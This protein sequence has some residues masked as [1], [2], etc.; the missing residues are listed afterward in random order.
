M[1]TDSMMVHQL[2][3]LLL[4]VWLIVI[5]DK[6]CIAADDDFSEKGCHNPA[7]IVFVLDESGSI[8]GPH[9]TK[10]LEFVQNVVDLFDV[11]P[12]K[13][14]L[15]VLTFGDKPRIIF[16]LGNHTNEADMK[17]DIKAIKQMRGETYTDDALLEARTKMLS[18]DRTRPSVPHIC[19][20]ITDGESNN[21]SLTALEAA[22][23]HREGIQL[24]AIGVGPYVNRE[25]LKAIASSPELVFE[26]DD[27]E[28]LD[29]L[30]GELAWKACQVSTV[31]PPT[32]TEPPP[33]MIEGC[34][35]HKPMDNIWAIPDLAD[36][37]ENDLALNLINEVSSEMKIGPTS[38]QVGL[39]KRTCQDGTPIRLKEHDTHEGL[40]QALDRR[41]YNTSATTHSHISYI[42]KETSPASGG[43]V[44][45]VKF[46]IL[47]VDGRHGSNLARAKNEA[48]VA[49][50]EGIKLI[51]IGVGD[52]V[53]Q[54]E[55]Q[56]L[57]TSNSD[58]ITCD[59][60]DDLS[61]LKQR[62]IDRLCDG[63]ISSSAAMKQRRINIK[64]YF[65]V[66]EDIE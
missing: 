19:I 46:G 52:D 23:A 35:G 48:K 12:T 47:I 36:E 63:L 55:L 50:Q 30:R 18:A 53:D 51:V 54:S 44:D 2:S 22:H 13:T 3:F 49:K 17:A 60:Y 34:T 62:I 29:K 10:Q 25:E 6:P 65:N 66:Y 5:S 45:A 57:A 14:R 37:R 38:V 61:S 41:R 33:Q 43:R 4:A 64:R 26:V 39:S 11:R 58:V 1:L 42:R 31:L 32:T 59:S 56:S 16:Q 28:A 9:F 40:R 7:D 20:V 21:P 27:Y 15:G 8:W 24:F